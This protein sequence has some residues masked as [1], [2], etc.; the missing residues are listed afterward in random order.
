[1]TVQ[2]TDTSDMTVEMRSHPKLL[3]AV[4]ELVN[5]VARATGF[6]DMQASQIA[7]ATDEALANVMKHGY[8]GAHDRPIWLSVRML[9]AN[10]E[11]PGILLRI[12]D[13]ARQVEPEQIKSRDLEE[14]RPGGLGVHI[15]RQIMDQ[16]VY[17]KRAASGMRLTMTKRR[18]GKNSA[19]GACCVVEGQNG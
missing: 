3:C 15:I 10:A 18:N 4:R 16:V 2:P 9:E 8:G 7:L 11:G 1:M 5:Q 17:E 12:E 6:S 19:P 13:E 14:I